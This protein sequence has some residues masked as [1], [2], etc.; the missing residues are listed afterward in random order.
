[1]AEL[2]VASGARLDPRKFRD[3]DVT[4]DGERRGACRAQ[5]ARYAVVQHRY[6]VQPDLR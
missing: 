5:I 2:S 6:A 3:P 4:A 1:M